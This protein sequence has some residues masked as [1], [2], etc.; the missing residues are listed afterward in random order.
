M[1]VY[2]YDMYIFLFVLAYELKTIGV[3]IPR[4][5]VMNQYGIYQAVTMESGPNHNGGISISYHYCKTMHNISQY[6]TF[7]D[8]QIK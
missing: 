5:F 2:M 4:L 7:F 1:Y 6:I 8:N 3:N